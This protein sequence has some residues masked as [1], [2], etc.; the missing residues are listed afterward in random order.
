MF[1]GLVLAALVMAGVSSA[2]AAT[3]V[4]F[5]SQFELAFDSSCGVG[6]LA[7]GTGSVAGFG[8]ASA[9][10]TS[11]SITPAPPCLAVTS[12]STITFAGG[13]I[14]VRGDTL[15][16]S[17]G[18]ARMLLSKGTFTITGGT[19][20]FAGASGGGMAHNVIPSPTVQPFIRSQLS[21]WLNLP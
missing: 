1:I 6:V 20:D 12:N 14:A 2:K 3:T 13:T 16:C 19:G 7:C 5:E 8:S 18:E 21:G 17:P 10:T 9:I 15:R 11:V 4:R